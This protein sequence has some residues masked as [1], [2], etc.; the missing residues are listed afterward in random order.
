MTILEDIPDR[1]PGSLDDLAGP[2][3]GPNG[4]MSTGLARTFAD[5]RGRVYGMQCNQVDRALPR[6]F[7]QVPCTFSNTFPDIPRPTPDV[8]ACALRVFVML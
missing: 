2:F 7:G 6:T 1:F 5:I 4:Q 8:S 3:Y